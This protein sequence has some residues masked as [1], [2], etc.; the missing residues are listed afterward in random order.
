MLPAVDSS[1]PLINERVDLG[2]AEA[3]ASYDSENRVISII[4]KLSQ[5][6]NF[7]I[8]IRLKDDLDQIT[9]TSFKF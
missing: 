9:E 7:E 4:G 6:G 8:K 2:E 1:R 3:F 5:A